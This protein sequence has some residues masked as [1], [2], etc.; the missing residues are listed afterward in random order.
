MAD[1]STPQHGMAMKRR[2]I[3]A[4]AGAGVAGVVTK[5]ASQPGAANGS[6]RTLPHYGQ[7]TGSATSFHVSNQSL[8]T[9]GPN[10]RVAIEGEVEQISGT[11]TGTVAVYGI[12]HAFGSDSIGVRGNTYFGYGVYGEATEQ[13]Y[14][15][16]G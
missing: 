7:T 3:L 10:V 13:G 6:T 1:E 11:S 12:N 8:V 4:A 2:G 15:M 16:Y 9:G 14:G 5:R